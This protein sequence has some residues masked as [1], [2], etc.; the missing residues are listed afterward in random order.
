MPRYKHT[1]SFKDTG[2]IWSQTVPFLKVSVVLWVVLVTGLLQGVVEVKSIFFIDINWS[3]VCA[4]T[5]PPLLR[6]WNTQRDE[7]EGNKGYHSFMF[8][9]VSLTPRHSS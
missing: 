1:W 5:K 3:Q 6:A 7:E 2:L 8:S 4:S 9:I